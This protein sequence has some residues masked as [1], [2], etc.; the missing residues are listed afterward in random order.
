[1]IITLA[2]IGFGALLFAVIY[3]PYRRPINAW[4]ANKGYKET[5]NLVAAAIVAAIV[6][7]I[8][9]VFNFTQKFFV[10][11]WKQNARLTPYF[12]KFFGIR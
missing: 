2:L 12:N 11:F 9:V 10:V 6:V 1:M 7:A 3:F 5:R 4:F 8:V